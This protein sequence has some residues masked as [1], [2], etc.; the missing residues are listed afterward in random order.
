M[1]L[2]QRI[3]SDASTPDTDR[4]LVHPNRWLLLVLLGFGFTT[5]A[6]FLYV[7]IRARRRSWLAWAAV[8]GVLLV[9]A[10]V[11]LT[12]SAHA[13]SPASGIGTVAQLIA[14]LGGTAHA[15]AVRRDAARRMRPSDSARLEAAR[16]RIERRAEGRRLA[17][18][19]PRLAR[20][21]GV[22]GQTF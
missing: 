16:Q 22:D 14:W 2:P 7:G 6:A 8:Y 17:A 21:V 18:K 11:L 19:D 1:T 5:W 10:G 3:P 9:V 12:G 4:A 13:N 15:T 20:E